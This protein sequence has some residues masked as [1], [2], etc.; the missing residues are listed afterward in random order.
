[1]ATPQFIT[2]VVYLLVGFFT[3]KFPA[4]K[5]NP[6]YGYRTKRSMRNQEAWDYAQR[7]SSRKI[8]LV[9]LVM[10][11][12]AFTEWMLKLP[13]SWCAV[14]LIATLIGSAIYMMTSVEARLK[15]KFK[16][17]EYPVQRG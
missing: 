17:S 1:M 3:V 10:G 12:I 11:V 13:P 6:L 2:A 4:K 8:I 16:E 15:R 14:I 5:I 9:G 7:I